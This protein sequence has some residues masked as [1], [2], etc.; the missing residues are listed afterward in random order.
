MTDRSLAATSAP[1]VAAAM[2]VMNVLT[3]GFN[4]VAARAL[5]P[6]E[7][8]ALTAL[9]S[10]IL[11]ANVVALALQAAVARRLAV[12]PERATAIITTASRVALS[13]ALAVGVTVAASTIVVSPTLQFGSSWPVILCGAML[14]PL[15]IAGAQMGV[16]QGTAQWRRLALMYVGN[17]TGR[18]VGGLM[19]VLVLP[20]ATGAMAGL[21]LG[22][23][24][25]VLLGFGLLKI[26]GAGELA[27]RRPLAVET[28]RA[29]GLLVAFFALSNLDA[30]LARGFFSTHDSGLYAA[31][32][33]MT[34]STL[35]L[36]QFVSVVLFPSLAR[37]ASHRSRLIASGL[38]AGLGLLVT[39][40]VA[41]LPRLALMLVGGDAYAEVANDL[42]LFAASGTALA[43]LYVL[44]F[45]ALA[46]RARGVAIALWC[47]VAV[48]TATAV[49]LR[50][51]VNELVIV[52][53]LTS[54]ALAVVLLVWPRRRP[55]MAE[56]SQ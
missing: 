2:M 20:T 13:V 5:V 54:S 42:W 53:A 23:W 55:S 6:A 8:G 51:G 35:F 18:I 25:P 44:V 30:L 52:V 48:V 43:V 1:A 45:D 17:G 27:S 41:L 46:R 7:F 56:S 31:G 26:D 49:L 34:K 9:L 36:P 21:A 40:G 3:Y 37:D 38:V 28:I 19:G 10:I 29:T 22:A 50:P 15:T 12:E 33:I 24:L 11:I 39:L 32:L 14:V 4:L 16:A 47:G